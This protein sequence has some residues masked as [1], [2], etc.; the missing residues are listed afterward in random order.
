ML[1]WKVGSAA[2][3][4]A[5][6]LNLCIAVIISVLIVYLLSLLAIK[7][8][9]IIHSFLLYPKVYIFFTINLP[10]YDTWN[11]KIGYS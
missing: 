1:L 11:L 4:K 9:N 10:L 7:I 6:S 8:F 3:D 2:P 5:T